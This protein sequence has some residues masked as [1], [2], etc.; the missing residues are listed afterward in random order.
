MLT[1]KYGSLI[2]M[3]KGLGIAGLSIEEADGVL[4]ISGTAGN[5]EEVGQLRA[6][7]SGIDPDWASGE[8]QL[9]VSDASSIS[10]T[11]YEVK[12]GDTLSGIGQRYG[13][14][15]QA[16]FEANRDILDNPDLIKPG[17]ELRIPGV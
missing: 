17:Q 5:A 14:S 1:D 11:T 6:E 7:A 2:E 12:P 8:L 3:A 9:E 15:W 16:I 4:R 13:V 10:N